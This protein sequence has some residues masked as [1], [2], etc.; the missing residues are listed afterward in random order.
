[1][2]QQRSRQQ[3]ILNNFFWFLGCLALAFVVW[4]IAFL[5]NDPIIEWRLTER[6]PIRVEPDAGLIITDDSSF[7][8][9]ASVYLQG[10]ESV[11]TLLTADDVIVV[12]DLS[13]MSTGTHVVPLTATTARGARV[14]NISPSQI[15]VTL[16][17]QAAQF[18]PIREHI[19][20]S[21]P[22][23]VEIASITFDVLQAEVRGPESAI[24]QVVAAEVPLDLENQR[25][26]Y[27]TDVRLIP[28][29][30]DG[31]EVDDVTITPQTVS[32]T[33]NLQQS[34]SIWELTVR[35]QLIGE[36]PEG[37][38]L[39]SIEYDPQILYVSLP[40]DVPDELP[41]TAFTEPINLDNR[42]RDFVEIANIEIPITGAVPM[43]TQQVTVSISVEA[44]IVT[45][46]FD[47]VSLELTGRRQGFSYVLEPQTVSVILTG[48]QPV[49]NTLQTSELRAVADVG[50]LSETGTF[51][52]PISTP[53]T[54][55][56]PAISASILPSEVVITVSNSR[57]PETTIEANGD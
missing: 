13:G 38:F 43:S 40:A 16:E 15:T 10:P 1:M 57:T 8:N 3:I 28:V 2:Q 30:V 26:T 29:N 11:R 6:V 35:P 33:A 20:N 14:A 25:A 19:I 48:P 44:Q 39:G 18:V 31:I 55:A 5:Q 56:N 17:L 41:D 23:D 49:L 34:D 47:A 50:S 51:R 32:V 4:V 21:P 52:V 36:L 24:A 42:T 12:A 53:I 9:T 54:T 45:R 22:P 37:Y 46:Q 7:T 27:T